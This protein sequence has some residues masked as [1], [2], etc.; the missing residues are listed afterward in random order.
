MV[1]DFCRCGRSHDPGYIT[2]S[3]NFGFISLVSNVAET[4]TFSAPSES[5]VALTGVMC[6][7]TFCLRALHCPTVSLW[8]EIAG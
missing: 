4:Q 3:D 6:Q 5:H 7:V 2:L 8:V 1:I